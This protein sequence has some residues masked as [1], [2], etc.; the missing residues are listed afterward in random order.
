VDDPAAGR[1]VSNGQE[2]LASQLEI[3]EIND[4]L[5]INP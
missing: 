3:E 1:P 4:L 2:R 5:K